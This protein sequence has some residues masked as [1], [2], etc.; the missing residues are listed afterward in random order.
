MFN[1]RVLLFGLLMLPVA[2]QAQT[3]SDPVYFSHY[4]FPSS[5]FKTNSGAASQQMWE[6]QAGIPAIYLTKKLRMFNVLWGRV[7]QFDKN[8][9]ADARPMPDQLYDLRYSII[10]R[11]PL[12]ERFELVAWPRLIIRSDL[13]QSINGRDFMPSALLH[14]N[15]SPTGN[16][17]FRIGLGITYSND[18]TKDLITLLPSLYYDSPKW[19]VEWVY[20]NINF[21]RKHSE[22]LEYGLTSYIEGQISRIKPAE[23]APGQSSQAMRSVQL[24]VAPAVSTRLAGGI[25]GHLRVGYGLIRNHRLLDDD[26]QSLPIDG[27]SNRLEPGWFVRTTVSYR[28][29][30][31][32]PMAPGVK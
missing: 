22:R 3:L 27:G 16:P 18:F 21:M 4:Y 14:L 28:L 24:L 13:E 2:V 5:G 8:S 32:A 17:N 10:L 12:S 6:L 26:Y 23:W 1:W 7:T 9:L 19:R 31:K 15:Y 29:K 11:Q 20:P 30:P 25:W